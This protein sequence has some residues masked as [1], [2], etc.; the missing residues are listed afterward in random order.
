MAHR[1]ES[2]GSSINTFIVSYEERDIASIIGRARRLGTR[3][4]TP[5]AII[6]ENECLTCYSEGRSKIR[7]SSR[8]DETRFSFVSLADRIER[9]STGV[10]RRSRR[11]HLIRGNAS[12]RWDATSLRSIRAFD[13]LGRFVNEKKSRV[14]PAKRSERSRESH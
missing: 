3:R 7:V 11:E 9:L 5:D 10:T 13:T 4:A 12:G 1:G 14:V 8:A 6:R 2:L